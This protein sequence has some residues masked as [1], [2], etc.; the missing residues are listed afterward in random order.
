[1]YMY[2]VFNDQLKFALWHLCI[3]VSIKYIDM[4]SISKLDTIIYQ[5]KL[6]KIHQRPALLRRNV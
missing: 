4:Q 1:M 3:Y 5:T 6:P 2:F